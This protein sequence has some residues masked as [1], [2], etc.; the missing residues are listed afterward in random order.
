MIATWNQ[1][2]PLAVV[3]ISNTFSTGTSVS[4]LKDGR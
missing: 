2:M 1:I 3:L 4:A